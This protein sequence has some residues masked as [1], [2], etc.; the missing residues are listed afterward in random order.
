MSKRPSVQYE[1]H[2]KRDRLEITNSLKKKSGRKDLM[3]APSSKARRRCGPR[4]EAKEAAK[5]SLEGNQNT[6]GRRL[7]VRASAH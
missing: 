3:K 4:K 1:Y 2:A 7:I 5:K 6:C